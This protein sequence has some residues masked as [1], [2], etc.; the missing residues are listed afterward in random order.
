[1]SE[2]GKNKDGNYI[3][4]AECEVC[5]VEYSAISVA[6]CPLHQSAPKLLAALKAVR[7]AILDA[8]ATKR[9]MNNMHYDLVGKQLVDAIEE[10]ERG[11]SRST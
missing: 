10:A 1:M 5:M 8:I 2:D 6:F 3:D 9:S 7:E 4:C 11:G